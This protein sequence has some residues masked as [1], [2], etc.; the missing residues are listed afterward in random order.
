MTETSIDPLDRRIITA[1]LLGPRATWPLVARAINA[2]E[3]TVARRAARLLDQKTIHIAASLDILATGR[4][5]PVFVRVRCRPGK[6]VDVAN[7]LTSWPNIRYVALISGFADCLVEIVAL[8]NDD[9]LRLTLLDL[10]RVEG[11]EGSSSAIVL[12][13]FTTGVSWNP[14]LL[15]TRAAAMLRADR[16]DRWDR[17]QPETPAPALTDVDEALAAALA[18]DGRM[19]WRDLAARAGVMESTARRRAARLFGGGALR[20]RTVVEPATLGLAVTA[21]LWLRVD[22][23]RVDEVA[24]H[25]AGHP[26]VVLL[27]A[28]AGEH[29]MY[30]EVAVARHADL[31]DLLTVTLGAIPGIRDVDVTL[32]LRTLKRASIVRPWFPA[33][34]ES[35]TRVEGH[36]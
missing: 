28:T 6:A 3:A 5:I 26:A 27:S 34:S 24:R 20:L 11:V 33:P 1:L 16:P 35:G 17:A 7:A 2:S 13:R 19:R 36:T 22:A 23:G 21:F 18:K 8:D 12:K 15:D 4:G 25:L 10:P 32:G 30:G 9:L 29:N 31:H 14:G